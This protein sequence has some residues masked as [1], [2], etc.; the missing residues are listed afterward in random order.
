[1][2]LSALDS[3]I[4]F[5]DA[6]IRPVGYVRELKGGMLCRSASPPDHQKSSQSQRT[7]G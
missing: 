6:Q 7:L 5:V 1:M 2:E 4:K 3:Q